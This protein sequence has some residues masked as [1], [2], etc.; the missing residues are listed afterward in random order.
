MADAL[1]I[2]IIGDFNFTHNA[3][4]ATN[5]AVDHAKKL[6]EVE[7][8]YYWIRIHEAANFKSAQISNYD[9]VWIAPGPY[10]NIF[11]L[12]GITEMIL[13]AQIPVLI[14]GEAYKTFVE[15]LIS[16]NNL[17]PNHE[18]LISDN[19]LSGDQFEKIQVSPKSIEL[20]R[21]YQHI[22]RVELTS[23]RY[24]LYPQLISFLKN[25][26]VDIEATNQ[27]DD[28]EVISLK[29]H[30]FCVASMSNVQICSTRE[31]PH[32]LVT[33]FINITYQLNNQ[34]TEKSA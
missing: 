5:L 14:T 33:S 19:L 28:P 30:P 15:V 20:Q 27:F 3:H 8:N 10:E 13:A 21:M 32:P 4:H 26:L 29:N 34:D 24:S 23:V 16:Q 7:L 1:K 17:N 25:D 12:H 9:A 2:A 22:D 31:M 11:F 18:K 6:L